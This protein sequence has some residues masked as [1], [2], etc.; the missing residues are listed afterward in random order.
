MKIESLKIIR[1]VDTY[2][3]TSW[4]GEYTDDVEPGLICVNTGEFYVWHFG[5]PQDVPVTGADFRSFR[6]YAGG[7]TP[8]SNAYAYRKCAKQDFARME[9]LSRGEWCFLDIRAEAVVEYTNEHGTRLE[10]LTS[11]GLGGVESD[12]GDYLN[13]IQAEELADLR[14]HLSQFGITVADEDWQNL[15]ENAEERADG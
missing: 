13:E 3:D 6:A 14:E 5:E 15:I 11:S 10:T 2:P 4:M 1:E 7:E 12:S 8:A 9:G